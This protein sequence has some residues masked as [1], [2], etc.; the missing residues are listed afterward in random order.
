MGGGRGIGCFAEGV[1]ACGDG[2]MMDGWMDGWMVGGWMVDG[3]MVDGWRW[4]DGRM[5]VWY[6]SGG[7]RLVNRLIS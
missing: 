7:S 2:G 5:D 1:T 4:M 3:W 6:D